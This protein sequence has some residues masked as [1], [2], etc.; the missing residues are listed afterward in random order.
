MD[1]EFENEKFDKNKKIV[2]QTTETIIFKTKNLETNKEVLVK[3]PAKKF[4]SSLVKENYKKEF[5]FAKLTHDKFPKNFVQV[6]DLME[7]DTSIAIVQEPE[8]ESLEEFLSQK[9]PLGFIEFLNLAIKMVDSLSKLHSMNIIHRDI[10]P[11]NFVL[12]AE[13]QPKLIDFGISVMVS[14]KS[15]SVTCIHP[16]GTYLYMR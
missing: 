10:K 6:F 5:Q 2:Y 3:H 13:N 12:T 16:T 8:V 9:A 7:T 11:G 4:P 14:R 1:E 15:P